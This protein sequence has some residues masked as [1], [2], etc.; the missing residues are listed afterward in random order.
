MYEEL[1]KLY[2]TTSHTYDEGIKKIIEDAIPDYKWT[3]D[4]YGNM[5]GSHPESKSRCVLS[6][7]LDMVKTG[8]PIK[9]VVNISGILFGL[10]E[11]YERTSIGADDKNGI[12]VLIQASKHE[13]KPHLV[14]FRNEETGRLGSK[15]CNI[16][17]FEDKDYVIVVDRKDNRQIIVEGFRGDYT[18]VLGACFM[19]ANPKWYY[20]KGVGC[21]ADSIRYFIDTINISCGYY[22]AHTVE[23]YTVLEEL[24][25][26]LEA[27][28]NFLE[29]DFSGIPWEEI[30][31][32]H[33]FRYK[34]E[35]GVKQSDMLFDDML[36]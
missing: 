17:W 32:L 27:V 13:T 10:D 19:K 29:M 28:R 8:A 23:E 25:E 26:T 9:N 20:E 34:P 11:K 24:N 31:E 5:Y 21:D 30:K 18:S 36:G 35:T 3:Y 16:D 4:T 6:S 33:L 1:I 12:W 15:A 14:F 7:H 2:L 22:N